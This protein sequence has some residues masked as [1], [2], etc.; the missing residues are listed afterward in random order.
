MRPHKNLI[1]WQKAIRLVK[2]IYAVANKF[3]ESERYGLISQLKRAAVSIPANIS[4]GAA[5][6]TQKEF[7]YF[8]HIS[9]GSLSEVDTLLTIS[10]DLEFIDESQMN[11]LE[12]ELNDIASLL[13][14]LIRKI[15]NSP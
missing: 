12:E 9:S 2:V 10:K 11:M 5:R 8:L 1:V 7:L 3:P 14:G 15:K 4:E 13:N 6:H